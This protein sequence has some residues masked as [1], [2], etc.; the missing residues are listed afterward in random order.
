MTVIKTENIQWVASDIDGV[1]TDGCILLDEAGREQKNIYVRD[2][3]AIGVGRSMGLEFVFIT[4]EDNALARSIARRFNVER[5]FTGAK[6]KL[7]VLQ[8][9]CKQ[10]NLN[11]EQVCYIGDSD[12][13]A[14]AIAWAGVGVA[15]SDGSEAARQ[16]ADYVT[17]CA[18]GKGVLA[19]VVQ[20]IG[21]SR[22]TVHL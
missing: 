22:K 19:E 9:F 1:L 14:A 4:G 18:G 7:S 2:L 21:T 10:E 5:L 20:I 13:D 11:P 8:L 15:P 16:A 12:R 17:K 6:D 3:D